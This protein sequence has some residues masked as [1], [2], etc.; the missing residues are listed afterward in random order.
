MIKSRQ[1]THNGVKESALYRRKIM[2][3]KTYQRGGTLTLTSSSIKLI[4]Y[5]GT[6][7]TI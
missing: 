1:L 2:N 5:K 7:R 3:V 6:K 4:N